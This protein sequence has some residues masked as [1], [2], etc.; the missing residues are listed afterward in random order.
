MPFAYRRSV[1][2]DANGKVRS[3]LTS[4]TN[5][6]KNGKKQGKPGLP[7]ASDHPTLYQ[8]CIVLEM[9]TLD[10]KEAFVRINVYTAETRGG[11][12]WMQY[13]ASSS[14][15]TVQRLEEAD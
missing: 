10:V 9:E 6:E 8:G 1:I 3:Y 11:W 2:K 7:G 12:I 5:W 13:P 4:H 14:R 15:Y